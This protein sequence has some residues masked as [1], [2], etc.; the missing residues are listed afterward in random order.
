MD[1]RFPFQHVEQRWLKIWADHKIGAPAAGLQ[2]PRQDRLTM[3]IPPPNITGSLHMGHALDNIIPDYFLRYGLMREQ[4]V[5]RVPGTDHAGIATQYVVEKN[6]K[7][8][9]IDRNSLSRDE[10]EKEL[11]EWSRATKTDILEQLTG[12][13]CLFDFSRTRFTM[14]ELCSRA[15]LHA[16]S[17]FFQKGLIYRDRRIINWCPRCGSALSDLELEWTEKKGSLWHI[18]YPVIGG[19]FLTVAT[20]RPETML[21]DAAVAVHP[22]DKRYSAFLGK[23]LILPLMQREIPL[24]ADK[25]VLKD[26]GTGAVKVT[27]AHDPLD[28]AIGQDHNL[29]QFHVIG[30]N[31][32]MTEQAGRYALLTVA[33]AREAVL[34][35]LA[36]QNL[37]VKEETHKHNVGACYRCNSVIEPIA[38]LQWFLKMEPL[39]H[40]AL[41]AFEKRGEPQFYPPHW[42]DIYHR[43]LSGLKDWCLSRQIIWGH[44]IP[45]WYCLATRPAPTS[46]E[47]LL[48]QNIVTACPPIC[49]ASKPKSCPA[50][51][52]SR[53]VQDS[54]VLDTWFSSGLWPMSVFGWP[55]A[56]EDFKRFYPTTL[57]VT[58]YDILYLWVARMIMMGLYFT[59]KTPF[60]KVYL[61]G[62]IR[63]SAGRKMSKSIGNVIDPRQ[64]QKEIG[65]DALRFALLYSAQPGRDAI[66]SQDLFVGAKN[67]ITKIWN[68]SRFVKQECAKEGSAAKPQLTHPSDFWMAMEINQTIRY[69]AAEMEKFESGSSLRK[70]YETFWGSFCDWY[71]EMAKLRL[72]Q[73]ARGSLLGTLKRF[74]EDLLKLLQPAM[75]FMTHEIYEQ[76]KELFRQN[77]MLALQPWPPYW[78][79]TNQ[80]Q[81]EG[82]KWWAI[83]SNVVSEIR[84]LRSDLGYGLHETVN[85]QLHGENGIRDCLKTDYYLIE[86][87]ARCRIVEPETQAHGIK[88]PIWN[89][90]AELKLLLDQERD[91]SQ[92]KKK[93]T[94]TLDATRLGIQKIEAALANPDFIAKAPQEIVAKEKERLSSLQQQGAKLADYLKQ[95]G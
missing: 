17:E 63:D 30:L 56:T 89:G 33:K 95:L 57:M 14:D 62:L 91:L 77:T 79:L 10:F 16:F 36:A 68:A 19:G 81:E 13:G 84:S 26:F 70:I 94:Q 92:E 5:L 65:T 67:F 83:F 7:A 20:T 72:T 41:E 78:L 34:K 44:R 45:I 51:G 18:N 80:Q 39:R 43:W 61:H 42:G 52:N 71:L 2:G 93:I 37:I 90:Q 74:L 25:R 1:T 12:L 15:V 31:G 46:E 32:R 28:W 53:I 59:G 40:L 55:G 29:A 66:L 58:G 3:V 49:C 22:E 82:K 50:C 85:I 4:E 60:A 86:G 64:L 24:I 35:D 48:S 9:G 54:D 8:K 6:L 21:G 73:G 11:K 75:P 23:R 87:L 27:P 88:R 76:L 47:E 69:I 38:S